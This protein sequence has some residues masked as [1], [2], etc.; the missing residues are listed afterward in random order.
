V[1][2]DR[3]GT[4]TKS[5]KIRGGKSHSGHGHGQGQG[6]VGDG[7]VGQG[8]ADS[9]QAASPKPLA[10]GVL[11]DDRGNAVWHWASE[12]A[13]NAA[14]ST[15]ALLKRLN[16]SSLSLDETR[17]EERRQAAAWASY[18]ATATPGKPA[19]GK[20]AAAKPAPGKPPIRSSWWRRL[21]QRR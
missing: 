14:V 9:R 13:R 17:D 8:Q 15:S 3:R 6:Q 7:Q 21:F 18:S 11:H 10:G 1:L 12:T 2:H 20:P 5:H 19:A 16:V 4:L